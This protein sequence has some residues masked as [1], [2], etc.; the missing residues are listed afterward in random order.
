[1]EQALTQRPLFQL[2]RF[3]AR[4]AHGPRRVRIGRSAESPIGAHPRLLACK[5]LPGWVP[6]SARRSRSQDLAKYRPGIS[7]SL[8]SSLFIIDFNVAHEIADDL[9]LIDI[10]VRKLYAVEFIFDQYRQ[11]KTIEP[12]GSEIITEVRFICNTSDIDTEI[13]SNESTHFVG[14]KILCRRSSLN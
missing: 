6:D 5:P 4:A 8:H 1:M 13:L 3:E 12:I 7:T 9:D 2:R 14:I 10:V 11:L